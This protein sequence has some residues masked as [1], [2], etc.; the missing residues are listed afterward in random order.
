MAKQTNFR[1]HRHFDQRMIPFNQAVSNFE[2][3]VKSDTG[4][5]G[6]NHDFV[7]IGR[8]ADF[9]VAETDFPDISSCWLAASF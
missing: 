3:Q 7:K 9:G 6:G 5:F 4:L 2:Q 1:L 8:L